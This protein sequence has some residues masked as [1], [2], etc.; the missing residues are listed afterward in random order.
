M[1]GAVTLYVVWSLLQHYGQPLKGRLSIAALSA[2]LLICA[3]SMNVQGV[4]VGMVIICC[5]FFC[6][7]RVLLGLGVVS[8]L[9]YIS[10][11]YY[12]LES[13]LLE[14][15]LSLL[16]VGLVLLLVRWFIPKMLPVESEVIHA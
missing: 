4:T 8:L 2:T 3:L 7:N 1:I 15:S 12:L 10:S 5:G 13:T 16:G 14:K 6:A 11:Y 9:F